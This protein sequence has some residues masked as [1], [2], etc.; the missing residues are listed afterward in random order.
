MAS[1]ISANNPELIESIRRNMGNSNRTQ[2]DGNDDSTS[3]SNTNEP[4]SILKSLKPIDVYI[5]TFF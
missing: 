1:E 4:T 5:Y 2:A 3:D